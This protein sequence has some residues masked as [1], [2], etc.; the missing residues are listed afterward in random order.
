MNPHQALNVLFNAVRSLPLKADQ[1]ESLSQCYVVVKQ[2]L[3]PEPTPEPETK[4]G[5]G[6]KK[7]PAKKEEK[8]TD[9]K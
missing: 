8:Q 7:K 5:K 9:N 2:S 6:K 4:K 3:P 1:H